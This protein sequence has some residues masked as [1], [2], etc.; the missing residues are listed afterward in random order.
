MYHVKVCLAN[1]AKKTTVYPKYKI[2]THES[3]KTF[4]FIVWYNRSFLQAISHDRDSLVSVQ[5]YRINN[6]P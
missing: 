3:S 4:Y 1:R 6:T 2:N 5:A